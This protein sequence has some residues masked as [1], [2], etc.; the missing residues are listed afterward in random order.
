MEDE[1]EEKGT[2]NGIRSTFIFI[3]FYMMDNLSFEF[4]EL[5]PLVNN[6]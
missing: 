5:Y 6:T 1:K 3:E 4:T 2:I